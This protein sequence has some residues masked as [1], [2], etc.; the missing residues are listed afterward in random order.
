MW[1]GWEIRWV[2]VEEGD[3]EVELLLRHTKDENPKLA[4]IWVE[5]NVK[6]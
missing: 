4:K 1:L 3:G 6:Q 2:G 5:G